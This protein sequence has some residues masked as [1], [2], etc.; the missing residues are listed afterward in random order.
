MAKEQE[1]VR[2]NAPS[3]HVVVPRT[4]CFVLCN[5]DVLVIK[6]SL[7]KRIFPGKINGV[8]GHVEQGEDVAASAAREILEETGLAVTNLWLAGVLHIDGRLGQAEPLPDGRMPGVMHFVFT[9]DSPS[10]NVQASGEGELLWVPL[11]DVDG[12]DWV[13]GDPGLLRHALEARATNRPF[14]LFKA[15]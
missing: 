1:S 8:G 7:H 13:D 11:A 9:A 3:C 14:S 10:C 2:S 6:R 5:G 4:L 15:S 12:L